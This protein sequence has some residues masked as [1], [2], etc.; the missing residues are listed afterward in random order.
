MTGPIA[1]A[2]ARVR[3]GMLPDHAAQ[4]AAEEFQLDEFEQMRVAEALCCGCDNKN[5]EEEQ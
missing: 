3:E 4:E 1:Y 2:K 5:C